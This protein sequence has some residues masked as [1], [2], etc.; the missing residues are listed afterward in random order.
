MSGGAGLCMAG[1]GEVRRG[2][3]NRQMEL[4]LSGPELLESISSR[5][6]V[7]IIRFCIERLRKGYRQFHAEELR[8]WVIQ[9]T[10]IAA[11]GSADRVLRDLRQRGIIAY[12]VLS[13]R[14]SLY[15]LVAVKGY[16]L[17]HE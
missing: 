2:F 17:N 9:E 11:P 5:I 4:D 15:V 7:S 12:H 1:R 16:Q 10:G 14:E 8:T 13:R 6:S 3:M